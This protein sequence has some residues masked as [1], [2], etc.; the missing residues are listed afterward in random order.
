MTDVYWLEQTAEDVPDDDTWLAPN[1]TI[2]LTTLR[3]AKRRAD[4]RLGRWTA[5]RAVAIFLRLPLE[6][7]SLAAIEICPAPSG[8]PEVIVSSQAAGVAISL[9]H[10]HGHA[11][12]TVMRLPG[13]LGCDLERLE[14]RSDAFLGDYFTAEEQAIVARAA[15]ADRTRVATLIWCAKES[16][17]KA[18]REG[19]RLDTRSVIASPSGPLDANDS[20]Q[21]LQVRYAQ[22]R[23]A[24][25]LQF[26]GWWR[27]TGD[28]MR[29]VVSDTKLAQPIRL[30]ISSSPLTSG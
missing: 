3:F 2:H 16:A 22:D 8:A 20:W 15:D 23:Y 17:L 9:S 26:H 4:W 12:C 28:F 24:D 1:E 25:D 14:T 11:L 21:P 27:Q 30:A 5:K 29:A 19:L 7:R 18:L 6:S 13:L 10:S